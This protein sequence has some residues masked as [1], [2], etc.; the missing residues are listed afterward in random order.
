M[1]DALTVRRE[2]AELLDSQPLAVLATHQAGHPYTSLVAFSASDDLRHLFFATTRATRKFANIS[3]DPR[4]S[5]LIDNRA[6]DVS[7]F[8]S[9]RAVTAK[10]HVEVLELEGARREKDAFLAR[11]PHLDRFVL[12]ESCAF[13][14]VNVATYYL[15]T[16]FQNVVELDPRGQ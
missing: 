2:V 14:C 5:M 8:R 6:N 11:H 3:A 12:A 10:G 13:L 9:A 4:V 15:V 1:T 16:R 7:D